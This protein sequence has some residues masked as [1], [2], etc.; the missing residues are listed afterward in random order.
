[1]AGY[2]RNYSPGCSPRCFFVVIGLAVANFIQGQG[3]RQNWNPPFVEI[4]S[5]FGTK[6]VNDRIMV[7]LPTGTIPFDIS[8]LAENF[9]EGLH[10][11]TSRSHVLI[12]RAYDKPAA[13]L[14][15]PLVNASDQE[16]D[17]IIDADHNRCDTLEAYLL[18]TSGHVDALG[19]LY[20]GLPLEDRIIPLRTFAIP[21][22]LK[23][24]QQATLV[25]LSKRTTGIHEL[26]M[27]LSQHKSFIIKNNEQDLVRFFALFS[28]FFFVFAVFS[29]GLTFRHRLLFLFGVYILPIAIG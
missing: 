1:M 3:H 8:Y 5:A 20:R 16:Q 10:S 17:M 25:L 4:D 27:T 24:Y 11:N 14:Y 6:Q 15:L 2:R 7:H 13:L 12:G 18:H 19:V 9:N 28:A 29:L 23:P 26:D 21:F 22:R